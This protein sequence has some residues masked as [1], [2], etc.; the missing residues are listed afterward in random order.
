MLCPFEWM[1]VYLNQSAPAAIK[2][3]KKQLHSFFYT[4]VIFPARA[5]YFY[6]LL[7]FGWKHS[8][9]ILKFIAYDISVLDIRIHWGIKNSWCSFFS[10]CWLVLLFRESSKWKTYY[11]IA[12]ID[13]HH[14]KLYHFHS[15]SLGF[16]LK[17]FFN[18]R[19]DIPLK[20]ILI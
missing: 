15:L 1:T 4:D 6:F 5:E 10:F 19:L 13:F 14:T 7:I 20:Y 3:G 2:R 17:I 16:I 12:F 11:C 18:F 9:I 8:C